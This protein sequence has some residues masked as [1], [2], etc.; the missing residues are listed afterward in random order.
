MQTG[1]DALAWRAA[2]AGLLAM[3]AAMGVG[4]FVYT[5]ILPH[6]IEAGVLDPGRAG[7]VAGFN[8]LGYLLGAV[9]ASYGVFAPKKRF[10]FVAGLVL[11]VAT[12]ALMGLAG[13]SLATMA[14][15]RFASGVA[16]AF[17]MIFVT[18]IAMARF[19]EAGKPGLTALHFGG[20]GLG[21][22][23][24]AA[25]TAFMVAAGVAWPGLWEAAAA[26]ALAALVLSVAILPAPPPEIARSAQEMRAGNR[27]SRPLAILIA[28]YGLFGFGYVITATFINTVAKADPALAPVEPW[29][30]LAVGLAGMPSIWLWNRLAAGM[31]VLPVYAVACLAEAAGIAI[32]VLAPAPATLLLAAVLLGGTF[33]A[34]TALGLA[35]ARELA[36]GNPGRAIALMTVSFGAGQMLGPVVAGHLYGRFGDFSAASLCAVAALLF[37]ALL[38]QAAQTA[39]AKD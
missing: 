11:S 35:R 17:A 8:Y 19:A 34:I 7:I 6:M 29:V 38:G 18:S 16:S 36:A 33:M 37:A 28:S 12:T 3:G 1:P 13:G 31:G 14:A 2:F 23:A 10:W 22:A 15:V 5:P 21:I 20:V 30:W 39:V 9:A 24:S 26:L 27:I 4:R 25:L 32:S